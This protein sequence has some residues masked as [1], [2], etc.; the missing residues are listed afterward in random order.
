MQKISDYFIENLIAFLS[1]FFAAYLMTTFGSY[2]LELSALFYLP[3]GA[4][5]LVYLLFGFRVL[6]GVLAACVASGVILFASWND[7]LLLGTLSA[8]AGAFAPIIVMGSMK[9]AKI[10]DFN[11]LKD[12][13]FKYILFMVMAV[14]V[15]SSVL[16]F[17]VFS[18]GINLNLEVFDFITH[19]IAGDV[20]GALLV[21]Y[22][23]LKLLV[24]LIQWLVPQQAN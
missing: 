14:S 6:P 1:V 18:K 3:L 17:F 19:Y 22:L 11:N 24:P 15:L 16:K 2:T 23:T 5:I 8:C 9:L 21:V 13:N 10:C 12:I 4:K 7:N 20:L